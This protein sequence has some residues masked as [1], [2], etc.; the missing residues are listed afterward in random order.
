MLPE[1]SIQESNRWT[2]HA[3]RAISCRRPS[4]PSHRQ[5][6]SG[7]AET[8]QSPVDARDWG[9]QSQRKLGTGGDWALQA[10]SRLWDWGLKHAG[11]GRTQADWV[12]KSCLCCSKF[13]KMC[14]P[15]VRKPPFESLQTH[16]QASLS[17]FFT[18]PTLFI[19]LRPFLGAPTIEF[20]LNLPPATVAA[21]GLMGLGTS[22]PKH[23]QDW[24]GLKT[25]A[26][27]PRVGL[28]RT[29]DLSSW[30]Q[31]G[32]GTAVTSRRS[33]LQHPVRHCLWLGYTAAL[34]AQKLRG[35]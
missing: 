15:T 3:Q 34:D 19:S 33:E 27:S 25:A 1:D 7:L 6:S 2:L 16:S 20:T 32:T 35:S 11:T 5:S 23:S 17:N 8:G 10:Q 18:F 12:L 4:F 31:A 13:L 24:L 21:M 22:A 9:L 30:L 28:E 26:L 29:G 14:T